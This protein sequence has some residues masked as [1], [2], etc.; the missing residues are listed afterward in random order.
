MFEGKL[1]WRA[2]LGSARDSQRIRGMSGYGMSYPGGEKSDPL[3][4]AHA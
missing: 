1:S 3:E 2:I 4:M